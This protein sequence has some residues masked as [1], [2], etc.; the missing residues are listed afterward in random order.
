MLISVMFRLPP[1]FSW[2]H[3]SRYWKFLI[4]YFQVFGSAEFFILKDND[5]TLDDTEHWDFFEYN[6]NKTF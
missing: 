1:S 5:K 6:I 4:K 3:F 2:R